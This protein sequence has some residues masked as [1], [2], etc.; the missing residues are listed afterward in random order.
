MPTKKAKADDPI[1]G[2]KKASKVRHTGR[3]A[4]ATAMEAMS[5]E[6]LSTFNEAM[7]GPEAD[8]ITAQAIHDYGVDHWGFNF[9]VVTLRTHRNRRCNCES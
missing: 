6:E 8:Y 1:A 2:M 5:P 4:V 9:H 3:C 7:F